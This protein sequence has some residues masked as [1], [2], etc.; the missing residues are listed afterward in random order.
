MPIQVSRLCPEQLTS[1]DDVA[2]LL[3][4]GS[5]RQI[6]GLITAAITPFERPSSTLHLT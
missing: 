3:S 2:R 6:H 1:V 4:R 5:S